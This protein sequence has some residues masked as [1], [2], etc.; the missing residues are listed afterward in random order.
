[1]LLVGGVVLFHCQWQHFTRTPEQKEK[2]LGGTFGI[3]KSATKFHRPLYIFT[4]RQP[5]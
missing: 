3:S 1:M 5:H 4:F 2:G